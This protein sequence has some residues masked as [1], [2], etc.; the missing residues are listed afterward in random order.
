MAHAH[1]NR[2]KEAYNGT[3]LVRYC[4]APQAGRFTKTLTHRFER[5]NIQ[6]IHLGI[7]EVLA[8]REDYATA[9]DS[10]D[11]HSFQHQPEDDKPEG[12]DLSDNWHHYSE[13]DNL[14]VMWIDYEYA[15]ADEQAY[16]DAL[17]YDTYEDA[18]PPMFFDTWLA[19]A[20][21]DAAIID[22][23]KARL[24]RKHPRCRHLTR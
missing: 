16:E 4:Y 2:T 14:E 21:I 13:P 22:A 1:K 10:D 11:L 20:D 3:R 24:A 19:R 17:A 18:L 9:F 23:F 8:E 15:R 6:D 5:R 12:C 7:Q